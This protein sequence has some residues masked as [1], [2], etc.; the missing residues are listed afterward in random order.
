VIP[1][2]RS[3]TVIVVLFSLACLV[4]AG[5]PS[6]MAQ[7]VRE[8]AKPTEIDAKLPHVLLIGD[9]ISIGYTAAVR[10]EL[11]G[12]AN[13]FRPPT[14]CGPTTNG[15]E[16]LKDWLGDR[17]WAVIHFNFGLHDLKYM[18]PDGKNLADPDDPANSKQVPPAEYVQN[19]TRIVDELKKTDAK[20]I[21]RQT[22]PVPPGS[23]GRI[24]DDAVFYNQLAAEVIDAAG[25][26]T[27]D[28]MHDYAGKPPI[29]GLQ[30]AANV[31]Y[32][33]EGSK[34]LAQRVA[35]AIRQSLP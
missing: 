25:D 33:P 27:T 22:T 20:L 24:A 14:N 31:H 19:L 23:K 13:V 10:D 18:S 26:I 15:V 11:A 35:A 9:S 16:N 8:L 3:L 2:S 5:H 30:R 17:R 7:S 1:R 12:V 28:P 34:K 29:A 6:A 21:W 4:I 32:T